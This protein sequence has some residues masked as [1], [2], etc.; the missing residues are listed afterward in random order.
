MPII[1]LLAL[2]P[3]E[4]PEERSKKRIWA[5]VAVIAASCALFLLWYVH[6]N[7]INTDTMF[8]ST[9][10]PHAQ[11]RYA[12]AHKRQFIETFL[13]GFMRQ[14]LP[15]GAP[16][17]MRCPD[18]LCAVALFAAALLDEPRE[19][20]STLRKH[21][22]AIALFF[23]CAF[24]IVFALVLV[25]LYLQF[26]PV[27]GKVIVGVQVRYFIAL[28]S[29]VLLPLLL[30]FKQGSLSEEDLEDGGRARS[31]RSAT[32]F[33]VIFMALPIISVIAT[34]AHG[35]YIAG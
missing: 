2:L 16:D 26:T 19:N 6:I 22:G 30:L 29:L 13:L 15:L 11:M 1:A 35:V 28:N 34:L 10:L 24:I 25:A 33:L 4:I 3:I 7:M 12:L 31:Y 18:W 23:W 32:V 14:T 9:A 21:R 27:G 20:T 5:L 8:G 17:P